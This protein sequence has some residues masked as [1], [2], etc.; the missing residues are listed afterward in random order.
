MWHQQ[1]PRGRV[2]QLFRE[3]AEILLVPSPSPE[4]A[5]VVD[6]VTA[7]HRFPA[8]A[9]P[10][11]VRVDPELPLPGRYVIDA[12]GRPGS[13]AV[14]PSVHT[15]ALGVL[16]EVGHYVDGHALPSAT[17][18]TWASSTP[19]LSGCGI[20]LDPVSWT[21]VVGGPAPGEES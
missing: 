18:W 10:I 7:V 2:N 3:P 20:D 8:H 17:V 4:L 12:Q 21:T 9:I 14:H 1:A 13:I 6:A 5:A 16:H 15:A 11:P 19:L